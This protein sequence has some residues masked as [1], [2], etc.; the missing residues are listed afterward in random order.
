M[1]ALLPAPRRWA[2]G[3]L[4]GLSLFILAASG[5]GTRDEAPGG[6]GVADSPAA[7]LVERS[8]AFHD[9][10]GAW[11]SRAIE[12][13][14]FGTGSDGGERVSVDLRFGSDE[15][16]FS[17]SGRYAGSSIE[18]E[19][20]G[21]VWAATVDGD[22]S[23]DEEALARMRLDRED[24]VFWRSYY[25]FLAGLPMKIA[26]PGARLDPEVAETTFEGRDV[27]AVRVTYDPEVGGDTWY[28]YFAADTAE[29]VGCRFYHDESANDGEYITFEGLA[30]G[31]GLRLPRY[32]EWYT[33]EGDRFLGSDEIR[34]V[35]VR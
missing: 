1:H 21:E 18:Y 35:T 6:A 17:L 25:G 14:W 10:E 29:L 27:R 23:P 9:P 3:H 34:S 28:F 8:I 33:N 31:G 5:C 24:G 7:Q 32:R 15:S 16:D 22:G 19:V 20:S 26:D 13:V 11:G 12:M 4:L 2:T 30:E